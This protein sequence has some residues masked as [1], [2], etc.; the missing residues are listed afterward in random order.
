MHRRKWSRLRDVQEEAKG[1]TN[2]VTSLLEELDRLRKELSAT[3]QEKKTIED[4]AQ[5]YK[6]EMEKMVPELKDQNGLLKKEKDDLNKLIQEQSQQ[7]TEK[8]CHRS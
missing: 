7:M 1:K 4:W 3:Q 8:T 6:D 2:Q 5:T